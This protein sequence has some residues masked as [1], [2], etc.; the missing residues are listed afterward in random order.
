MGVNKVVFGAVSIM[1]ITD[2]TVTEDTLAEGAIAYRA[3]GE[4]ITGTMK[5]GLDTSDATATASDIVSGKTAYVNGEKVTGTVTEIASNYSY[6]GDKVSVSSSS[7]SGEM[8][9]HTKMTMYQD[10]LFR[11]DKALSLTTDGASYGDA[12]AEDVAAGKTFTSVAGLKVTGTGGNS[13]GLAVRS[14]DVTDSTVIE[15]GLSSVSYFM[16]YKDSY[17]ETGLLQAVYGDGGEI[18]KAVYC[19]S[20]STYVKS[21]SLHSPNLT[22]DGGTITYPYGSSTT[23]GMSAGKTYHWVAFGVE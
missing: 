8:K 7:N 6:S 15:T 20:Y 3:D 4:R 11:K 5:S 23:M 13:G 14:G 19:A 9:M 22:I 18:S 12:T 2:S 1:D 21:C 10:M 16:L 17:A